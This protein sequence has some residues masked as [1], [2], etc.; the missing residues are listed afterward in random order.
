MIPL[1]LIEDQVA[2][3]QSKYKADLF[4]VS[5]KTINTILFLMILEL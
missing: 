1:P 3:F 2:V 5:L 4:K